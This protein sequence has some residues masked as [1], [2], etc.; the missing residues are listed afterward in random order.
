MRFIWK[1]NLN[2]RLRFGP[3]NEEKSLVYLMFFE[4]PFFLFVFVLLCSLN[5]LVKSTVSWKTTPFCCRSRK[6][7]WREKK[8]CFFFLA[9]KRLFLFLGGFKGQNKNGTNLLSKRMK[10]LTLIFQTSFDEILHFDT[11]ELW[12]KSKNS[13]KIAVFFRQS[14]LPKKEFLI[15]FLF[16]QECCS[17]KK[18]F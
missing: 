1:M 3:V 6:I 17:T 14:K 12:G 5:P 13:S 18:P 10:F 15:V 8:N 7:F 16:F 4:S 11:K 2:L 9:R